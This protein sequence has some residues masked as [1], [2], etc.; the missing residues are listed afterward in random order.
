MGVGDLKVVKGEFPD[1]FVGGR[2][3]NLMIG[4]RGAEDVGSVTAM[5]FARRKAST[6]EA[7][8]AVRVGSSV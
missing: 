7:G 2:W 1:L 4:R 3:E 8:R 5:K 6:S